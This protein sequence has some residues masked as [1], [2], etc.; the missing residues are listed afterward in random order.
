M[1]CTG[2]AHRH[3]VPVQALLADGRDDT[4]VGNNGG[5]ARN[6]VGDSKNVHG[7]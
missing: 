2:K 5:A 1:L 4:A 6:A 7:S 3:L